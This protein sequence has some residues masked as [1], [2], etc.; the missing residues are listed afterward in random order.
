MGVGVTLR[1]SAVRGPARV[2][3]AEVALNFGLLDHAG[4][5]GNPSGAAQAMQRAIDHRYARGIVAAIFEL[6]QALDQDGNYI[7]LSDCTDDSAHGE[8]LGIRDWRVLN[9][10][11]VHFGLRFTGFFHSGIVT[12]LARDSVSE[13][14]G[15]SLVM[16]LPAPMVAPRPMVTGATNC[17]SEPMKAPS[18]ITV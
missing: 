3:D 17:V 7:A 8:R 12:C 18:S 4:K 15:A 5:R 16:V 11:L 9:P 10:R 6:A 1:R 13:S 14:A 2:S